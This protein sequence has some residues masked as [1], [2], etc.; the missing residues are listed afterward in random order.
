MAGTNL[1]THKKHLPDMIATSKGH[2]RQEQKNI[3]STQIKINND[4]R[5]VLDYHPLAEP[6]N[7]KTHECYLTY[8]TKEEGITYLDLTGIYP[9]KSR[10]GN[11]YII[12]CYDYDTNSIQAQLTKSR[13]TADIRD[14][15]L[16]MIEKLKRSG[17]PLKLHIMDN[18]ASAIIKA[19]L[20]KHKVK[21]QL[22]PPHLHRRNSTEHAIQAFKAHFIAGLCSTDPNYP[23]AEWDRLVSQAELTLN[24]LHSC[25]FNPKLSA[26]AALNGVFDFNATPL[27]PL[28]TK[29]LLHEKL[30]V[31]RTW[32]PRGTDAFYIG[33]ALEHYCCVECYMPETRST[34][35]A[36]K[37]EYFPT[38]VPFSKSTTED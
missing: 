23:A 2:L 21:Y 22:V 30:D 10:R 19:A 29:V 37:L 34:R 28:G 32:A 17:H 13:N 5:H 4:T 15:T 27:V 16:T 24:L 6:D 35:I 20:L 38:Q 36:D 18:E 1:R 25:R 14:A 11:Q 3:Q 31:H 12:I 26:Y 9:T 8:F 33:P 7:T